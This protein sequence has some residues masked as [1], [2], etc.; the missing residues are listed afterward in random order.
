MA[1]MGSNLFAVLPFFNGVTKMWNARTGA[2]SAVVAFLAAAIALP[3]GCTQRTPSAAVPVEY[4][5]GYIPVAPLITQ[6]QVEMACP[7]PQFPPRATVYRINYP[8]FD[9]AHAVEMAKK[10][11]VAGEVR[12]GDD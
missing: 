5:A 1:L 12:E 4:V 8:A 7:L 3:A 11:A 6:P 10:F 9:A 2:V